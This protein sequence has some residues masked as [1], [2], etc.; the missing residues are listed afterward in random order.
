VATFVE[1]SRLAVWLLQ[2]KENYFEGISKEEIQEFLRFSVFAARLSCTLSE[3][4]R[5]E[6]CSDL[7]DAFLLY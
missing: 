2:T 3:S 6:V 5:V 7:S 1:P 4:C